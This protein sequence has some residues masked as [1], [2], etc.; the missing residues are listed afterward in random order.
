M[1]HHLYGTLNFKDN[2]YTTSNN[3]ISCLLNMVYYIMNEVTL[4]SFIHR[5]SSFESIH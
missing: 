3:R 2:T 1:G 5:V 4:L